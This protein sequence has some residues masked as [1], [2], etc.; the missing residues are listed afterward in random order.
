MYHPDNGQESRLKNKENS[1]M[2]VKRVAVLRLREEE[3]SALHGGA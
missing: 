3:H 1:W 2:V